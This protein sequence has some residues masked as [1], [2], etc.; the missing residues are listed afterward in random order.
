MASIICE[1]C[2]IALEVGDDGTITYDIQEWASGCEH[3]ANGTPLLCPRVKAAIEAHS[4]K[5][6][7]GSKLA[8]LPGHIIRSLKTPRH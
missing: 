1:K 4:V 2:R 6:I 7:N 8:G 5:P 3:H